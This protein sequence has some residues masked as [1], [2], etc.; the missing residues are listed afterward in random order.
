[1]RQQDEVLSSLKTQPPA[2][3]Q[4]LYR[5]METLSLE[6]DAD[7]VLAA[8]EAGLSDADPLARAQALASRGA[9]LPRLLRYQEA[10]PGDPAGADDDEATYFPGRAAR[11]LHDMVANLSRA[12]EARDARRLRAL[13]ALGLFP[14]EAAVSRLVE[15]S[16][17]PESGLL[18]AEAL[19]RHGGPAATRVITDMILHVASPFRPG[20]VAQLRFTPSPQSTELIRRAIRKGD[21]AMLAAGAIALE[22]L[23]PEE[24]GE[25]ARSVFDHSLD[26]WAALQALESLRRIGRP[27]HAPL[28]TALVDRSPIPLVKALGLRVLGYLRG[29]GVAEFLLAGF[30]RL[31]DPLR[32]FALESLVLV[33]AAEQDVRPLL[34]GL[35][36]SPQ[37]ALALPAVKAMLAFDPDLAVGL[38]SQILARPE[39]VARFIGAQ[40]LAYVHSEAALEQLSVMVREDRAAPVR[41]QALVSLAELAPMT[42]AVEA[43]AEGLS[44]RA[45][46]VRRT[47]A[48]VIGRMAVDTTL[49]PELVKLLDTGFAAEPD[50]GHLLPWARAIAFHC[51]PDQL[52][53]KVRAAVR[54]DAVRASFLVRAGDPTSP[55][56]VKLIAQLS[57]YPESPALK[58]EA[59]LAQ[60]VGGA[61]AGADE[62]GR[63]LATGTEREAVDA[64]A[65]VERL[66][67]LL[68]AAPTLSRMAAFVRR[69][70]EGKTSP[71][72]ALYSTTGR[73]RA[74]GGARH[75]L[76][77]L[78]AQ[79]ARRGGPPGPHDR[80]L[81][82]VIRD[83]P[84]KADGA[85]AAGRRERSELSERSDRPSTP[86]PAAPP[87][88]R[89]ARVL[90]QAGPVSPGPAS[91][92]P[93]PAPPPPAPEDAGV[94][95]LSPYTTQGIPTSEIP[96]LRTQL[97]SAREQLGWVGLLWV[98][99]L[100]L[101]FGS[102]VWQVVRP[103]LSA[104]GG[105]EGRDPSP[106]GPAICRVA[107]VRGLGEVELRGRSTA[108]KV[109]QDVTGSGEVF[110]TSPSSRITMKDGRD[111]LF[112]LM[113]GSSSRLRLQAS[114]PGSGTGPDG[115]AG[116]PRPP[117][118]A[119]RLVELRDLAGGLLVDVKKG[120]TAV[121]LFV[122]TVAIDMAQ[123]K[124]LVHPDEV[125]VIRGRA[126]VT[127][128]DQSASTLEAG[129]RLEL[130]STGVP[131]NVVSF[132]PNFQDWEPE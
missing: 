6:P 41:V 4:L 124:A 15:E 60:A 29:P 33:G 89:R 16:R 69:V 14:G 109:G 120:A 72:D 46:E 45:P 110:S 97:L 128:S 20:Q 42:G 71:D 87:D 36:S 26:G 30:R 66:G 98:V 93:P 28:V 91:E 106:G 68:A 48:R 19:A 132:Q 55:P 75:G 8:L 84:P 22:G 39:P 115:P 131:A 103:T 38:I 104:G 49:V 67:M 51:A 1:L 2:G 61:F 77:A 83:R 24:A 64:A 82:P 94:D 21:A 111:E 7:E 118:G 53:E 50:A 86:P 90:A 123:T 35:V 80:Q 17:K 112:V 47:A 79:R 32:P 54:T 105:G 85:G 119:G 81:L 3:R 130:D 31:P 59:C 117:S 76:E 63:M 56:L 100:V 27:E 44:D 95:Q 43:A 12:V 18:V 40:C 99:G 122:G 62:L 52:A 116:G 11:A 102:I 23:A 127:R 114:P 96:G 108:V 13:V 107:E 9:F 73:L 10:G 101:L 25:L 92:P 129:Q 5:Q 88:A 74:H 34:E 78:L 65:V 126:T 121:R 125:W 58:A 37:L 113:L 57:R 70:D